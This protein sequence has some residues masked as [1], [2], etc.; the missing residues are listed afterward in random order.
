MAVYA[1]SDWH[2]CGKLMDRIFEYLQPDD[3]LYFL[4]DAVDRGKDGI[5]ILD[6]LLSDSR[7]IMLKGNHEELMEQNIPF[8]LDEK[9]SQI[10][11]HWL[12]S[13]GGECTWDSIKSLPKKEVMKYVEKIQALPLEEKYVS[14]L[15]HTVILEHAGYSPFMTSF[16]SHDSLWDRKHFFDVW[17]DGTKETN[18]ENVYL[19]H[20]HTPVQILKHYYGYKSQPVKTVEDYVEARQYLKN[21]IAENEDLIL[22]KIIRYCEGHKFDVDMCT[23]ASHR[24]ALLNL[25][26]FEEIYF[27]DEKA[28]KEKN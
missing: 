19:V 12:F 27:D 5:Q 11:S 14:P 6:K 16:R 17:A 28:Q 22:P 26:T 18:G 24:I 23:I 1:T 2:G 9:E 7:V 20:G 25:D 10:T 3:T 4:G 15:G 13:N 21:R 8:L